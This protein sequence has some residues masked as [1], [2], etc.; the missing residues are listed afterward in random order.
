[1]RGAI[2]FFFLNFFLALSLVLLS[3]VRLRYHTANSRR[4]GTA[5]AKGA[6][7]TQ[8]ALVAATLFTLA[9]GVLW[10]APRAA[11]HFARFS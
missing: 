5:L 3:T 9:L 11:A 7:Y 1:M 8:R 6:R 2:P 10:Y 4:E